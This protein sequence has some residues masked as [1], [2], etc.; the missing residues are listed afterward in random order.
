MTVNAAPVPAERVRFITAR[1]REHIAAGLDDLTLAASAGRARKV[2]GI[3]VNPFPFRPA[4]LQNGPA[5][6]YHCARAVEANP[7][8]VHDLLAV[9]LDEIDA[10][11]DEPL[12][13]NS[14]GDL[15][16]YHF[17]TDLTHPFMAD[18]DGKRVDLLLTMEPFQ[19]NPAV[20]DMTPF[21]TLY[22]RDAR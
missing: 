1:L 13:R 14:D 4:S 5:E 12:R 22:T 9:A 21:L 10:T 20:L 6:A 17:P 7:Q 2:G 15:L 16:D 3:I 19:E 8:I 11:A 18:V